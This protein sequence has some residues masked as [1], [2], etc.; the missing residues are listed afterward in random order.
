MFNTEWDNAALTNW[1]EFVNIQWS[2]DQIAIKPQYEDELEDYA[3]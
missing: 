2:L 1:F 3:D